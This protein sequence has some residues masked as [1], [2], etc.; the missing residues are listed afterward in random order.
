MTYPAR[1]PGGGLPGPIEGR[2]VS[3]LN[4][5]T[6]TTTIVNTTTEADLY[7]VSLAPNTFIVSGKVL[8]LEAWGNMLNNSAGAQG[9]RWKVLLDST[10]LLDS[11]AA[12]S[13]LNDADRRRWWLRAMLIATGSAT[14]IGGGV[15]MASG[16]YTESLPIMELATHQ[17][18]GEIVGTVDMTATRNFKITG[19]L[20][21]ADANLDV[22][23]TGGMLTFYP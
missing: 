7:S 5:K 3:R 12:M 20:G 18:V 9:I 4:T 15:L 14:Q 10:I 1:P 19:K 2:V 21:A 23:C 11:L 17:A 13:F 6:T 8:V 22:K 16:P